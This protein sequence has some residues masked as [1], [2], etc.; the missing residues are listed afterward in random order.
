MHAIQRPSRR[1][2]TFF[3]SAV[4]LL[5]LTP[6]ARADA[7]DGN[8]CSAE[9]KRLTITGPEIVTPGGTRMQGNYDRHH[10]DYVVP[11]KEAGAGERVRMVLQGEYQVSITF[12]AAAAQIWRRCPPGIS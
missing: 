6:T 2:R 9:G 1:L 11:E 4:A 12:G 8:W 10:F 7:I 3:L 5:A